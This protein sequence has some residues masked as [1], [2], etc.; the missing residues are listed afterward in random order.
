VSDCGTMELRIHEKAVRMSQLIVW[1]SHMDKYDK[2]VQKIMAIR[3]L[4]DLPYEVW[5]DLIASNNNKVIPWAK[6]FGTW[7]Y[8]NFM[9]NEAV[10]YAMAFYAKAFKDLHGIESYKEAKLIIDSFLFT[11][12][13][14]ATYNNMC[15]NAW[16]KENGWI[17]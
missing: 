14:R 4:G 2:F 9:Q 8:T 15:K 1:Q 5:M 12:D 17:N 10:A 3:E 6:K 13:N 11:E 7:E 16:K